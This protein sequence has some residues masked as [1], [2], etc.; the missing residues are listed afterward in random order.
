V[1]EFVHSLIA[2]LKRAPSRSTTKGGSNVSLSFKSVPRLGIAYDCH[3][4]A[5]NIFHASLCAGAAQQT[6][7]DRRNGGCYGRTARNGS[8]ED[9]HFGERSFRRRSRQEGREHGRSAHVH[10]ACAHRKQFRRGQ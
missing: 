6:V 5:S 2:N 4:G 10:D 8:A 7:A 1:I 3:V 9:G